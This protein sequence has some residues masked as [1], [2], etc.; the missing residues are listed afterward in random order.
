M[1]NK[2]FDGI[3][4]EKVNQFCSAFSTVSTEIFFDPNTKRLRHTGEYGMYREAVVR[5]F[6]K[7]IV[8]RSLDISTGFIIT[9]MDDVST[10]CDAI[11]FDAGMT[12]L[13]QEGD[14]QRFFPIE[15]VFCICEVKST[16]S[17]GEFKTAINKLAATK[18]LGERITNPLI[19]RKP[20]GGKFDPINHP[21]DLAPSI[22]ICQKLNFNIN[23]I[24]SEIDGF[25]DEGVEH[26]HKHNMILSIEDGLLCYYDSNGV[27]LP[28]PRLRSNL[29]SRFT[30]PSENPYLHLNLFGSFMY[31]ITSSKTLLYPEFTDYLGESTG[32]Y[33]RDQP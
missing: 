18:A 11:I 19:I 7:F 28:Y 22:L 21:Y 10:Q 17:K 20:T 14:R 12:P 26:R 23:S 13:Y 1:S 3:Y 16:L 29:K 8:P 27:T 4:K 31:M 5:D 2:I 9:S 24:E 15:S 32:G 33:K 25:Y 30:Y 6:L